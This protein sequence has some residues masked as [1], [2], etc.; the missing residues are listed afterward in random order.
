[1]VDRFLISDTHF[2]HDGAYK[3]TDSEGNR[4]R[5]W[6]ENAEEGDAIMV[7][8]W[9]S[10]VKPKDKVYHLGDV[11]IPR[12]GLKILEQL[13]GRKVLVK[14]N[15]DI[16]KL[17]DFLK[18]FEEIHGVTKIYQSY[19]THIPLHPNCLPA[20]CLQNIHGHMHSSRME[21]E[22]YVNVSVEQINATPIH[23]DEIFIK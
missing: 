5:P 9:N 14:G 15:H 3:F 12:R 17:K 16:F 4:I 10:V 22:R 19:L 1:M 2:G 11:A 13:Q 20:W 23:F 6:A 8:R 18:Y 7:E 21:D